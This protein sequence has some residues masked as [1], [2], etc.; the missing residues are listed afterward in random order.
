MY[1]SFE[2]G[3][4]IDAEVKPMYDMLDQFKNGKSSSTAL[5]KGHSPRNLI[6]QAQLREVQSSTLVSLITANN[7]KAMRAGKP[8]YVVLLDGKAKSIPN[9]YVT[10]A[11]QLQDSKKLSEVQRKNLNLNL[12]LIE[13]E[14]IRNE[15]VEGGDDDVD[16]IFNL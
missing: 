3:E 9:G 4:M 11:A 8:Q 10:D 6:G 16:D 12:Q 5:T 14:S 15:P 2:M 7:T 1:S 13:M